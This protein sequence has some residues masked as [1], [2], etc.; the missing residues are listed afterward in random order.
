MYSKKISVMI[1]VAALLAL[2]ACSKLTLQNYDKITVGMPY[3]S[4]VKL[5]GKPDK[6][7]DVVGV[8]SCDWHHGKAS[9]HVNFVGDQVLIYSSSNLE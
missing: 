3:D 1:G 4:V 7:D 5:I 2:S 9:V 8:R 6:C